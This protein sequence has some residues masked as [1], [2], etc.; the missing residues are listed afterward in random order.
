MT[1]SEHGHTHTP[2]HHQPHAQAPHAQQ[3]VDQHYFAQQ[4]SQPVQYVVM[5]QSVKGVSG[6]VVFWQ[7]LFGLASL[8]YITDFFAAMTKNMDFLN[9][10][11]LAL[12][13]LLAV[14]AITTV[15]LIATE[16]RLARTV[17][18][19]TI[20]GMALFSVLSAILSGSSASSTATV[21][22]GPAEL[23]GSIVVLLVIYG[24]SAFYFVN[25]KRV[26]ETLVK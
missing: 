5:A 15:I 17:A 1:P 12:S 16:K 8:G 24:L 9:I 14:A 18:I 19:A 11:N 4:Q 26:K 25:A 21:N 6:W 3:P 7:I 2:S 13:P 10:L 22:L 23:V 20:G